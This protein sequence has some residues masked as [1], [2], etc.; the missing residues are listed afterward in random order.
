[1]GDNRGKRA[2]HARW[3]G[4]G[5]TGDVERM[6]LA[7]RQP[8]LGNGGQGHVGK[9]TCVDEAGPGFWS[10][11]G[12]PFVR[13]VV[14]V[15]AKK[16]PTGGRLSIMERAPRTEG[17]RGAS[18]ALPPRDGHPWT[19]LI[20]TMRHGPMAERD[21]HPLPAILP[22]IRH[23]PCCLL[24]VCV[25][26][27]HAPFL[28]HRLC[29]LPPLLRLRTSFPLSPSPPPPLKLLPCYSRFDQPPPTAEG[30]GERVGRVLEGGGSGGG[31]AGGWW[32]SKR[33]WGTG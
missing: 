21:L 13:R 15:R 9:T 20:F 11:A 4:G 27:T 10:A 26:S 28:L 19:S 18:A 25:L 17:F 5:G 6:A 12:S 2:G 14:R 31:R 1:M 8:L 7:G 30:L 24:P 16:N 22:F 32:N 3:V 29:P 23:R 33:H